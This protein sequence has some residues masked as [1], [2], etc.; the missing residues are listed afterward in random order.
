MNALL[1]LWAAIT[2]ITTSLEH[3][4]ELV[5]TANQRLEQSLGLNDPQLK[6]VAHEKANSKK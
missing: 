4:K 5:D 6:I 1:R 2:G 3:T